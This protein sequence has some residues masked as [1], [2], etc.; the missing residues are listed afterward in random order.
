MLVFRGE[1]RRLQLRKLHMIILWVQIMIT[2]IYL[3]TTTIVELAIRQVHIRDVVM[4]LIVITWMNAVHSM[5]MTD[6]GQVHF[7]EQLMM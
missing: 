2:Q 3:F 5:R 7:V 1:D 4:I 6:I